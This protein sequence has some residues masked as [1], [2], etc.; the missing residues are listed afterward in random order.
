M[1]RR[2]TPQEV[3][4]IREYWA[5]G[6]TIASLARHYGVAESTISRIVHRQ[7]HVRVLS[8]AA[9]QEPLDDP[10]TRC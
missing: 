2:F 1:A 7:S 3:T 8:V 10:G 4:R 6:H 5:S 9:K